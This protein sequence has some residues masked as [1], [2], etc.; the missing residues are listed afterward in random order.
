MA[1]DPRCLK[2][3]K[4]CR[5]EI[6]STQPGSEIYVSIDRFLLAIIMLK[7]KKEKNKLCNLFKFVWSCLVSC[8]AERDRNACRE[9]S[10][11]NMAL[12]TRQIL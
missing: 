2:H 4:L 3:Y 1:G 11:L 8:P 7:L 6:K 9:G 10:L 5:F 12:D